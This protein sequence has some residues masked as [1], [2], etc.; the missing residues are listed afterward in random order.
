[1]APEGLVPVVLLAED[2]RR[3]SDATAPVQESDSNRRPSGTEAN[4]TEAAPLG[5]Q[6]WV[7]R[8]QPDGRGRLLP[9]DAA[10]PG[11]PAGI[12]AGAAPSTPGQVR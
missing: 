2:G 10:D 8:G 3:S 9:D 4:M 6:R 7:E 5:R 12:S 11:R 1:M